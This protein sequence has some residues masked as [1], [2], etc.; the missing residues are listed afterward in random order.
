MK[1]VAK[2][3]GIVVAMVLGLGLA[4]YGWA[5][6]KTSSVLQER[7]TA[8]SIDFPVPYP[9]ADGSV[10]LDAAIARGKHLVEARYVCVNCHGYN[11]AGG[12]MI[13]DP[14]IGTLLGPNLTGGQGGKV[15]GYRIADWDLAVRH[16]ILPDGR[17]SAM[18]SQ[19]FKKM[20]DQE[21][22]DIIAYVRSLPKVDRVVPG[23]KLGPLGKVLI[24]TGKLELSVRQIRD[25]HAMHADRAPQTEPTVVFGQHVAQVCVG[26]HRVDFAGGPIPGAPP[27][28]APAA[29]LT[30][31]AEGVKGWTYEQFLTAMREGRRPNGTPVKAPMNEMLPYTKA[32]TDVELKAMWLYLSG[33]SAKP[34]G[35]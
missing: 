3:L 35:T 20:T 14:M 13:D 16:G 5:H 1:K 6:A 2:W 12:T 32:M 15:S 30:P 22:S 7:F 34:T 26:C 25:H 23:L 24:A 18:P 19:D 33:V 31:H 29:N 17:A 21:L 4:G 27:G 28:W 8:H 11:F 9:A 10:S